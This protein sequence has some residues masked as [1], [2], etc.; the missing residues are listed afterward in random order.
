MEGVGV[1][2]DELAR[3]HD[4]ETRPDLVAKLGLDLIEIQRQLT[5]GTDFPACNIG[6]HFFVR[7]A[8]TEVA[9]V[10]ILDLEHLRTEH[11]PAAAFLP[12]FRRL[13]GR[14]Q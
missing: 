10:A 2:H 3:A 13:D 8:E 14:H 6:Y 5:M 11:I 4:P 7:R 12:E 1:L 9:L